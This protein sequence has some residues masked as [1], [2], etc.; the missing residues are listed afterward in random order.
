MPIAFGL[1]AMRVALIAAFLLGAAPLYGARPDFG[2]QWIILEG[3]RDEAAETSRS[4]SARPWS[5]G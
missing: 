1:P 2:G 3:Q 5:R 4:R